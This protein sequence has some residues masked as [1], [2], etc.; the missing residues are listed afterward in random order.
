M[1]FPLMLFTCEFLALGVLLDLKSSSK[2]ELL[3][4]KITNDCRICKHA[5]KI[6]EHY[7]AEC[8]LLRNGLSSHICKFIDTR[9]VNGEESFKPN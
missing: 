5:G 2:R 9:I 8:H 4:M 1:R 3:R 6:V 7:L